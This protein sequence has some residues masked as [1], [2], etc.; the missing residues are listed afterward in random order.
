MLYKNNTVSL[1]YEL[2]IIQLSDHNS[3]FFIDEGKSSHG[4]SRFGPG[5]K[6]CETLTD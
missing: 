4:F 2:S 6:D 1:L 3:D 5:E